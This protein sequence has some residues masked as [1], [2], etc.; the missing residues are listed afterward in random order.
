MSIGCD[1]D[2]QGDEM[3]LSTQSFVIG[4]DFPAG[5]YNIYAIR[6]NGQAVVDS[7][8]VDVAVEDDID[9]FSAKLTV[10]PHITQQTI[11]GIDG[12]VTIKDGEHYFAVDNSG[13]DQKVIAQGL[14]TTR[15]SYGSG[16]LY[17]TGGFIS[18]F[19][20]FCDEIDSAF[21]DARFVGPNGD[22]ADAISDKVRAI[23]SSITETNLIASS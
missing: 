18:A 17:V 6:T 19:K 9:S 14:S 22:H 4:T 11:V 21:Q 23:K 8:T 7:A 3:A 15:G 13:Q 2:G 10:I 1:F 5:T 20:S 12:L 16:Q